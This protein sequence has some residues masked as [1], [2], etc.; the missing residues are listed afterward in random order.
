MSKIAVIYWSGTG[1]TEKM[2]MAIAEGARA[3][4]ADVEVFT[5][6]AFDV[7]QASSFDAFAFGCP[8]MGAEELESDEFLPM[9]EGV[10]PQLG[11]KKVALFGSYGWGDGEWMR[12]WQ[13]EIAP[14]GA[15]LVDE[16]LILNEQPDEEG[17]ATCAEL[18][19][20]LAT[21]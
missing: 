13:D 3:E 4:Q 15:V 21:A 14:C 19:K 1:N 20:K 17:L 6:A 8:S 10:T 16:G 9:Y 12:T 2:A 5:A 7:D 18:G 11:G